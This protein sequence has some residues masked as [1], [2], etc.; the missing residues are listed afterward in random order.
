[1]EAHHLAVVHFVDVVAGEH[2]HIVGIKLLDEADVL[3]D[4]VRRAAIPFARLA[5]GIGRKHK[6]TAAVQIQIPRLAGADVAVQLKRL[7]LSQHAD[8]VDA[9]VGA[10]GER[11]IN[12]SVFTAK[13][14]GRLRHNLCE[15]SQATALTAGQQHCDTVLLSQKDQASQ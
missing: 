15:D 11:K 6:H 12:D 14:N 13:G 7:I 4:G 2:Q 3:I 8:G 1:M 9:G 10:V 5:L